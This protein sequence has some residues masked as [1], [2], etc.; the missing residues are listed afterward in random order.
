[1]GSYVTALNDAGI[2]AEVDLHLNA[3][4]SELISDVGSDDFQNPLPESN[5]DLFWKS[6]GSYFVNNRA[7]IFGVFN[8]PFPPNAAVNGDT[9]AGWNC[10]LNGCTVP[11]Y[12]DTSNYN[13]IP[14][15]TY[16][17]EG[18]LQ[19][20]DDIRSVNTTAPLLV[21]GPDFAGD[22]DQWLSTFYPGGVS[23]DPSNLLAASVHIYFPNGNSPCSLSTD[24]ATAC[25]GTALGALGNDGIL[26]VASVAP[27]EIDELGDFSCSAASL[28]PFLASVDA[29]DD[30]GSVD[31]GYVGWAWTTSSCDPNLITSYT[32][33]APSTM[34][35]AEYCELYLQGLNDGSLADCPGTPVTTTTTTTSPS[36]TTTTTST[37]TTTTTEPPTTTTTEPATTTTTEPPTT[38][39]TEPPTTTTTEP[40]TTTTTEPATTTT[41]EPPTTTTTEPPTTTTTTGDP[42][43]TTTTAD[44]PSTTTTS[45]SPS[46]PRGHSRGHAPARRRKFGNG[47]ICASVDVQYQKSQTLAGGT[48][49][50][51]SRA[52]RV[53][54]LLEHASGPVFNEAEPLQQAINADDEPAMVATLTYLDTVICPAVVASS[55][56]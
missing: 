37:S 20:I 29:A 34:G 43:T 35:M 55:T 53:E 47:P 24:V 44:P 51:L 56:T 48:T 50:S 33:G 46:G 25:P 30:T 49:V 31:V 32:T 54:A 41:T 19:M 22:L 27:V 5:S 17:G 13:S 11:D 26:Q 18:M 52:A 39:T 45:T 7:V 16:A 4:G 12:T 42:S 8:E 14:S 1:M 15:G 3:P 9:S 40:P 36:T 38:T 21:G 23:V 6:V 2:Y 10:D 28:T